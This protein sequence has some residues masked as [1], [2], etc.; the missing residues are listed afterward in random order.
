MKK[1]L[2]SSL[3]LISLVGTSLS[4]PVLANDRLYSTKTIN[5]TQVNVLSS[6]TTSASSG[7]SLIGIQGELLTPDK[8]A[9]INRINAI[10]KEAADEGLV[11]SYV[12]IKW[13]TALE[14]TA[15]TRAVEASISMGHVRLSNKDL[16]SAFPSGI[17]T[18]SENLAWNYGGFTA[19]IQQ[20][21]SEK[22]DYLKKREG[23]SV[24]GQTGHY[25]SLIN[26]EYTHMGLAAFD[27]PAHKNGWIAVAQSLASSTGDSESLV[28]NYGPA[29]L[30]TEI[31]SSRIQEISTKA[32]LF[33]ESYNV[34]GNHVTKT[35]S[36]KTRGSQSVNFSTNNP[37][38][39]L[40]FLKTQL[41]RNTVVGTWKQSGNSWWYQYTNGN[42]ATGWKQIDGNWYFFDNE[43]WMKT[44]WVSNNG[45]WYYMNSTGIMKT[46]WLQSGNSW[47]FLDNSGEMKT[48]WV[49]TS[50]AWYYLDNSGA[51][52]TG[53]FKDNGKWYYAYD[54]GALAMNTTTPDGYKVN[55][56]GELIES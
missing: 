8:Q 24:S 30:Y 44:G 9:I 14:Q 53:W 45:S 11:A 39:F 38:E 22:A 33:D 42:Y 21:Y 4:N 46:G 18:Y 5:G 50:G 1:I 29:I 40:N 56:S 37:A 16:Q 48:G 35:N 32:N 2:L 51:M 7:N 26:P 36:F 19:A 15:I 55:A 54:S 20:W 12:P 47:Y 27:N 43:G 49:A 31:S 6:E 28:G 23:Q 17:Y 52:K 10:R 13:S 25:E 3:L 41:T 34:I